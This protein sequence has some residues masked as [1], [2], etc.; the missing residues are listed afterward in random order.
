MEEREGGETERE[1]KDRKVNKE[2]K[3]LEYIRERGC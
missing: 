2:E 1:S 3:L